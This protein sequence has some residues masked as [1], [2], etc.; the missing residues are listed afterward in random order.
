VGERRIKQRIR[1]IANL[2]IARPA[3]LLGFVHR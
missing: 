3:M 2:R 1:A